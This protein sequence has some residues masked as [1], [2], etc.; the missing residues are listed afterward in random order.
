MQLP[1]DITPFQLGILE[2]LL[3]ATALEL[4]HR[5]GRRIKH[6][7][8]DTTS[9]QTAVLGLVGLLLAFSFSLAE[10]RFELRKLLVV[11]EANAIGTLYLRADLLSKPAGDELRA[12][13]R[14][15]VDV[16]IAWHRGAFEEAQ[17]GHLEAEQT[18]LQ[19]SMWN[20]VMREMKRDPHDTTVPL[21]VQ[22]ANQVIDDAAARKA[23]RA[24]RVPASVV[25]LLAIAVALG[26]LTIGYRPGAQR[27]SALGSSIFAVLTALT[28][29]TLL[30]LDRP[31]LGFIRVT[32][33][34]L[35]DARQAMQPAP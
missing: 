24:N 12:H 1:M 7:G 31:T 16:R 23:A 4:G 26:A 22:V 2:L 18:R 11:D 3:V 20:V 30:D 5:L 19:Q 8:E 15:Y 21:A 10:N 13:L 17:R 29:I 34:P 27:R 35:I 6:T 28:L 9:P 25:V 32:T 14:R 33:Q